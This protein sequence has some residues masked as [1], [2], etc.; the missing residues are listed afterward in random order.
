MCFLLRTH[1]EISKHIKDLLERDHVSV[2]RKP[3]H[4]KD[5]TRLSEVRK[6]NEHPWLCM[7]EHIAT[8]SVLITTGSDLQAN[9]T[10]RMELFLQ[11]K[12]ASQYQN[13]QSEILKQISVSITTVL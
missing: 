2:K 10:L 11:S 9:N 1:C 12:C 3:Y 8:F 13:H 7:A 5:E 4:Q 6:P